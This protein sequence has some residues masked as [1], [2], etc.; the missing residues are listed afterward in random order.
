MLAGLEG[1][2][3]LAQAKTDAERARPQRLLLTVELGLDFTAAAAADDL[4]PAFPPPRSAVAVAP[5]A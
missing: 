2:W 4:E 1:K 5:R 3:R